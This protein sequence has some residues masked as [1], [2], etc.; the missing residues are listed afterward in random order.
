[1]VLLTE[2]PV[3]YTSTAQVQV[4]PTGM[5]EQL[6]L[7]TPRQREPLNLDTESQI[8]QSTVVASIAAQDLKYTDPE[9]LREMVGVDVPPNSAILS[10]SFTTTDPGS[11]AK[12]AQAFADAYLRNRLS[13]ATD[14]LAADQKVIAAKL[15][16]V[17]AD[18]AKAAAAVPLQPPGSAA[19][20][21]AAHRQTVLARQ[22]STLTVKYD[23]LKTV[24]ITP[25]TVISPARPPVEPSAPS[26]P[27]Y[28][29]SGLFL[30]LLCGAGAAFARDRLDTRLR[31]PGDVERLTGLPMLA[32]TAGRPETTI[33][34]ELAAVAVTALGDGRHTLLLDD[35]GDEGHGRSMAEGLR[36]ALAPVAPISVVTERGTGADAAMLL[37]PLG[38]AT[39]ADVAEAVRH[40]ARQGVRVLGVVAVP[41]APAAPVPGQ[42]EQVT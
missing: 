18:L 21:V 31:R 30:G 11:A 22:A 38:L 25:G 14:A 15:R 9:G 2:T 23:A 33:S 42:A 13:S 6:N 19:R 34:R 10:I 17:N 1:M 8:A 32:E 28:L 37:A 36:T 20:T 27:I 16:Q 3:S 24:A 5:Q 40:L 39:S 4:F 26:A 7:I 29:G 35:L 41:P 12:G